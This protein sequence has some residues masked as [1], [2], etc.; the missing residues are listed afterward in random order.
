MKD[1]VYFCPKCKSEKVIPVFCN[2]TNIFGIPPKWKC[3][4][5]GYENT[6]FPIK[7]YTK[8]KKQ[9]KTKK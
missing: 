3:S 7:R 4:D 9:G 1:E 2:W 5:C 6:P 8:L